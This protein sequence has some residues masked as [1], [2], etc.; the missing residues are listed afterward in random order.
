[1]LSFTNRFFQS[2]LLLGV[3]A[4]AACSCSKDDADAA[5]PNG[6]GDGTLTWT[7]NGTTYTSKAYS[8]A[9]VDSDTS[10][11]ITGSSADMKNAVS[12]RLKKIYKL[13][14]T[15]YDLKKG[16]VL[17]NYPVGGITL[18][19][20]TQFITLYGPSASNGSIV[21]TQYDRA[22]QKVAGTFSFTGGPVPNS[23]ST[24]TQSVTNGSFSFTR[25]R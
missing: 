15:T 9:I 24:G 1:M 7:H 14:A 23:G 3:L 11:L 12:L 8:S 13:G 10:L 4:A 22:A 2:V 6:D 17:N 18:N 21:V 19:S 20:A 5:D 16:S 25:F